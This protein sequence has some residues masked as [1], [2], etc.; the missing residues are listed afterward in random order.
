M[1]RTGEREREWR[2]V[3]GHGGDELNGIQHRPCMRAR[4]PFSPG[5]HRA[6]NVLLFFLLLQYGGRLF[7]TAKIRRFPEGSARNSICSRITS[8]RP[9]YRPFLNEF[10]VE[11]G[12]CRLELTSRDNNAFRVFS[13]LSLS[14]SQLPPS[15][16][17]LIFK[18]TFLQYA[19]IR[20]TSGSF[21][22][23]V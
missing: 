1:R 17:K 2:S 3:R 5:M 8:P 4:R 11:R 13:P 6:A 22:K 14:L 16:W 19:A 23:I 10:R 15:S 20:S 12:A 21:L 18:Q 9:I 7:S